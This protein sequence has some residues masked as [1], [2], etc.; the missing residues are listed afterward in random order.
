ME[1]VNFVEFRKHLSDYVGKAR[2][3]NEWV[4][5]TQHG[6]VVG[7]FVS[8]EALQTLEELE[9]QRDVEAFDR[10]VAQAEKEGTLSLKEF[11][12]RMGLKNVSG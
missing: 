1:T 3:A 8:A 10:G 12:K 6:K 4:I 9:M 7:G 5:V 11:A 2:F